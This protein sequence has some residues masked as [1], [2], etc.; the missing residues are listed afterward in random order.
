MTEHFAEHNLIR[1][2]CEEV[3]HLSGDAAEIGV[4]R[5]DSAKLICELLPESVVYLFDT[6]AGMPKEMVTAGLDA[7]YAGE[8]GDTSVDLVQAHLE[9]CGNFEIVRGEFS[10]M[11]HVTPTLRFVH[12]DC[13]LYKSTKAAIEWAWPLLVEGGVILDDDY[14]CGSCAGAAKAIDEFAKT[15]PDARVETVGTRAIIRR[16]PS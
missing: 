10:E 5:G 14:H 9:G 15:N 3:H 11:S 7:H 13:D 6:F 16:Q 1:R 4:Y 8:Y 12:I 2:C